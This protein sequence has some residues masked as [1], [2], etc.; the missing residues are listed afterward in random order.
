MPRLIPEPQEVELSPGMRTRL[1]MELGP[2][3]RCIGRSAEAVLEAR[4]DVMQYELSHPGDGDIADT[5]GSE[6]DEDEEEH[7]D[8]TDDDLH[9]LGHGDEV[10]D[11]VEGN[12]ADD[13]DQE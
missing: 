9:G 5:E 11:K 12:A 13:E 1:Y 3:L 6:Q 2:G 4:E 10:L 7:D 8:D